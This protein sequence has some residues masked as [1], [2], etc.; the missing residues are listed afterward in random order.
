[1]SGG[2]SAFHNVTPGK[3]SKV[4]ACELLK[5]DTTVVDF[6]NNVLNAVNVRDVLPVDLIDDEL[7]VIVG[8]TVLGKLI[9]DNQDLFIQCIKTG[10]FYVAVVLSK[11]NG[12]RK[13]RVQAQSL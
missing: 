2:G 11:E 6:D 8:Q 12:I 4:V 7:T 9:F 3:S 5:K 13:V 1:M 10:T